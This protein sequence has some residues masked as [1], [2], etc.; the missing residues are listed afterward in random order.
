MSV[1]KDKVAVSRF[2]VLDFLRGLA[3]VQMVIFHAAFDLTI[4]KFL[5]IN[6][7]DDPFWY[8]FPRVIVFNFLICVGMSL[9]LVHLEKINWSLVRSRFALLGSIALGITIVT[10]FAF[11]KNYIFFG[12]IDAIALCSLFGVFFLRFPK[13]S[14]IVGAL[15]LALNIYFQPTI[16]PISKWLGVVSMDYIPFIPWFG[17]TLVGIYLHSIGVHKLALT[18]NRLTRF[19]QKMGKK[20]LIIYVLHQPVLFSLSY[21]LNKVFH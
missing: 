6:F 21:L 3:I 14:G 8:P 2:H 17:A 15:M 13:S 9:R 11:P 18:Q 10:Y 16:I 7:Q 5:H 20:S 4:F 1:K 12:T 19:I